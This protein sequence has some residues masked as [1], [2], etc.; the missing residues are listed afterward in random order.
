MVAERI[1]LSHLPQARQQTLMAVFAE[2]PAAEELVARLAGLDIEPD[3]ISLIRVA[4]GEVPTRIHLPAQ[5]LALASSRASTI[6]IIV[7]GFVALLL[8]L[9][10][11]FGIESP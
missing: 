7:G 9:F 8:G 5:P 3:Q 1:Q 11:V 4:L 6:G 2:E 10:P